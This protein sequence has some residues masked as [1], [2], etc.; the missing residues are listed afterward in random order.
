MR[1]LIIIAIGISLTGC[2]TKIRNLTAETWGDQGVYVGYWEGTCKA[3]IGCDAGDGFVSFC[4]LNPDTNTLSC[5]E[6]TAVTPLLA[7]K[8]AK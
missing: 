3:V 2:A 6:Q 8:P 4:A 1:S 5:A 7:R